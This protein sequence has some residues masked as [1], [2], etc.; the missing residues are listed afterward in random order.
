MTLPLLDDEGVRW[1][2]VGIPDG[3]VIL[4]QF[5]AQGLQKLGHLRDDRTLVLGKA[6][7]LQ[8]ALLL[9]LLGHVLEHS[10]QEGAPEDQG[11]FKL[12]H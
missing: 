2:V 12:A 9:E 8:D 6:I 11:R 7:T 10:A 4:Q 5:S 3:R 1:P